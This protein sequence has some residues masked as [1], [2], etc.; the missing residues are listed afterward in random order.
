MVNL[1]NLCIIRADEM[2]SDPEGLTTLHAAVVSKANM[3]QELTNVAEAF[4]F[5]EVRMRPQIHVQ[6]E[7][8]KSCGSS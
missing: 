5:L 2:F 4:A 8:T 7:E 1:L 6:E 3:L